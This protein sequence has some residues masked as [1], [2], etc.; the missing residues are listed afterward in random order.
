MHDIL[1]H[2]AG[3]CILRC[4]VRMTRPSPADDQ[5]SSLSTSALILVDELQRNNG[6]DA[7]DQD[8][9]GKDAPHL[10]QI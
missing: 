1:P 6:Y 9:D 3:L 7:V 4:A 10:K 8:K 2:I 5:R